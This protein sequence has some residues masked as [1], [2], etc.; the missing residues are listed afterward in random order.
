MRA[1]DPGWETTKDGAGGTWAVGDAVH[2]GWV[3]SRNRSWGTGFS[4]F[5]WAIPELMNFEGHAI[6]LDADQLLLDDIAKLYAFKPWKQGVRC[7]AANR[8]DV[9][10]MNCAWF[11]GRWPSIEQMKPSLARTFEYLRM[12]HAQDGVEATLPIAWNDCDGQLFSAGHASHLIHYTTVPDG[13]PWRPYPNINYPT[14]FPYCRNKE[15]GHLWWSELEEALHEQHGLEEGHRI[16]TE[17]AA[18]R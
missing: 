16:Y 3:K 11:K 5:R 12:I 1:G 10:V 2:G 18:V 9:M 6:Y 13:Q 17:H 8:T 15:I 4:G 7:T 14:E